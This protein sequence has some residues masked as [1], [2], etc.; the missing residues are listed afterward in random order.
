[1]AVLS[2]RVVVFPASTA[3]SL[4]VPLNVL[5]QSRDL[6]RIGTVWSLLISSDHSSPICH[7]VHTQ[8]FP[9]DNIIAA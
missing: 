6:N 7:S 2:Q 1:M 5:F 9:Q 4:S 3:A 8:F